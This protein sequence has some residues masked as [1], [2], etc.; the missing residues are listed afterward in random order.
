MHMLCPNCQNAI[1][2]QTLAGVDDLLCP[3]CGSTFQL[4][5]G[6]TTAWKAAEGPRR[7]GKFELVSTVGSGA[8]G[9]V[10]Q[11]H[12]VELD[13]TVAVKVPRE[14]SL[15]AGDQLD[16]FLREARSAAQLRHPTIVTVHEVGRHEGVPY[17]VSDFVPGITLADFLT[18]KRLG[19][20]RAAELIATLAEAL[21]Y[22]HSQ[23]VIHRDVKPS[24]ILLEDDGTPHLTDFGLARRDAGDATITVE[25]QVLGTPAYMSPEQARGEAHA[26][27]G[28][29]DVYSLGV[30][31]YQLLT[32]ELPFRGNQ[33]MLLHQVLRDEPRAPRRLNDQIP[34]D[35]E[36]ICLKAMAKEPGRR[37]QTAAGLAEDLH[38]YLRAEP[39]QARPIGRLG[40]FWRWRRR[41]PALAAVCALAAI[42]LLAGTVVSVLFALYKADAAAELARTN[43]DLASAKSRAETTSQNL[44]REKKRAEDNLVE[45]ARIAAQRRQTLEQSARLTLTHG[46]R[47]CEQGDVPTG[48]LWMARSLE[49]APADSEAMQRVIRLNLAAWRGRLSG[50]RSVIATTSGKYV[51]FRSWKNRR[52]EGRWLVTYPTVPERHTLQVWDTLA[53]RPVG[54]LVRQPYIWDA[55]ISPDGQTVLTASSVSNDKM[56][57]LW[58]M[59]TGRLWGKPMAHSEMVTDATFRPDG[60]LAVTATRDGI[61]RFWR[62]SDASPVGPPY[63]LRWSTNANSQGAFTFTPDGKVLILLQLPYC[64]EKGQPGPFAALNFLDPVSGRPIGKAARLPPGPFMWMPPMTLSPDGKTLLTWHEQARLWNPY[65]GELA[66]PPLAHEGTVLTAAFSPDGKTVV[67]GGTDGKI[68]FWQAATG[69]SSAPPVS[70]PGTVTALAYSRDGQIIIAASQMREWTGKDKGEIHFLSAGTHQFLIEAA[71]FPRSVEEIKISPTGKQFLVLCRSETFSGMAFQLW[72]MATRQPLTPLRSHLRELIGAGFGPDGTTLRTY[73]HVGKVCIWDLPGEAL[74]VGDAVDQGQQPEFSPDPRSLLSLT[75]FGGPPAI[76]RQRLD[77]GQAKVQRIALPPVLDKGYILPGGREALIAHRHHTLQLWETATG[78]P[79]GKTLPLE[80]EVFHAA[81]SPDGH[82]LVTVSGASSSKEIRLWDPITARE[83]IKPI[84]VA[85]YVNGAVFSPDGKTAAIAASTWDRGVGAGEVVLLQAATGRVLQRISQHGLLGQLAFSPDSKVLV[86]A[87][88]KGIGQRWDVATGKPIGQPFK[89][90]GQLLRIAFNSQGNSIVTACSAFRKTEVRRWAADT[91]KPIGNPVSF[92]A[93]IR[94]LVFNPRTDAVLTVAQ[95]VPYR[96]GEI[97]QWWDLE[98]G[99]P[100]GKPTHIDAPSSNMIFSPDGKWLWLRRRWAEGAPACHRKDGLEVWDTATLRPVGESIKAPAW[101]GVAAVTPDGQRV[102]MESPDVTVRRIDAATGKPL[103]RPVLFHQFFATAHSWW[104]SRVGPATPDG[105]IVVLHEANGHGLEIWSTVTGRLVGRVPPPELFPRITFFPPVLSADGKQL[106]AHVQ[107]QGLQYWDGRPAAPV[108][109]FLAGFANGV[110]SPNG[111]TVLLSS[112]RQSGVTQL[113][114]WD[115]GKNRSLSKPLRLSGR[116][117]VMAISPN[118]KVAAVAGRTADYSQGLVWL[119]RVPSGKTIGLLHHPN[120]V[121]RITFSPD[122]KLLLTANDL[123]PSK[124]QLWD[125]ATAKPVGPPLQAGMVA[126]LVFSPDA[127]LFAVEESRPRTRVFRTPAP[128]KGTVSRIVL[129]TEVRTGYELDADGD[130]HLL[131]ADT[132]QCFASVESGKTPRSG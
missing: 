2:L 105:K 131:D 52:K 120:S 84:P 124:V 41:N 93:P 59:A 78:R 8:F 67:T 90:P 53:G 30:I 38:R 17:L 111:N 23:G 129:E 113:Q 100:K 71:V 68:R 64:Q 46:L 107:R 42:A 21:A 61:V 37:Y 98:S 16:R 13:R 117:Y 34:R 112:P 94:L 80:G 56:T 20:R 54:K 118:G 88:D 70:L 39:I 10:Y 81:L 116:F 36:T 19:F 72:D 31:L 83:I 65:K 11:A 48:L 33:R 22:A 28:R 3:A 66:V 24:N 125:A 123:L 99:L 7:I 89:H 25:G 6:A 128:L 95:P 63:Q 1:E 76:Y 103:G 26:V 44:A 127:Q 32:G 12:D 18:G 85:A 73:T 55:E 115:L 45:V 97:L 114:F 122:S 57:R 82:R 130:V 121:S 101:Q 104:Y 40:R 5:K 86:A 60:S 109:R 106:L 69:K 92:D 77:A 51:D 91:G 74:T 4:E 43:E 87:T 9:T 35:L 126:H 29:S 15:P 79:L 96:P 14:G 62:T 50:L 110:F 119:M 49:I 27:D 102:L 132:W 58:D 108:T 75:V 47:L